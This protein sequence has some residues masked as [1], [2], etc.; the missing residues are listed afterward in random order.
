MILLE[1]MMYNYVLTIQIIY[2]MNATA[3]PLL[4][5]RVITLVQN[6]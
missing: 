1:T 3:G 4:I 6:W 2:P 5:Q